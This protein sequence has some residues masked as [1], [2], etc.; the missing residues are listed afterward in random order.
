VLLFFWA[1]WCGDCK[2]Q[3]PVLAKLQAEFGPKGLAVMA[4]TQ[5][6]GYV[7]GGKDASP[8]E[9][10]VYIKKVLRQFYPDL[11]DVTVTL[12]AADFRRYGSSTTP[13]VVRLY[14][15]GKMSYED[16]RAKVAALMAAPEH[17]AAGVR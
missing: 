9:E 17:T 4:P 16:L 8:A 6:Y 2:Q 12:S 10:T 1:H 3:G 11:E 13:T 7:A 5:L 15:P 14:H